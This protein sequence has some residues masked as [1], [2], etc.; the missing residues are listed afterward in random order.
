MALKFFKDDVGTGK[1]IKQLC[2]VWF[3]VCAFHKCNIKVTV[4]DPYALDYP[5]YCAKHRGEL[6]LIFNMP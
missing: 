1:I 5:V 6:S 2:P 3:V 4:A